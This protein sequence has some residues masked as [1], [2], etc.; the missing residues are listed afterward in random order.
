M[1]ILNLSTFGSLV[2]AR[3]DAP[4]IYEVDCRQHDQPIITIATPFADVAEHTA[5]NFVWARD[6]ATAEIK[7][8]GQ[9]VSKFWSDK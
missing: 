3:L 8:N 6:N 2:F 9:P 1:T 4:S 5:E 7:R